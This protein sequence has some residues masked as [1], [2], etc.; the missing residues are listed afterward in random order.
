R[1]Q[2]TKIKPMDKRLIF[3]GTNVEKFIQR[4]EVAAALDGADGEDMVLQVGIFAKDEDIQ[5]EIEEMEGY[6]ER[7]WGLLK[8]EM[9]EKWG[10][11]DTLRRYTKDDLVDLSIR[12]SEQGGIKDKQ[13]YKEFMA[14]FNTILK[15]LTRNGYINHEDEAKDLLL[16]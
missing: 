2:L 13:D 3:D 9:I 12:K 6:L 7:N 1:R 5:E 8:E 11:E 14:E 16:N 10:D 15:Y 4:Y